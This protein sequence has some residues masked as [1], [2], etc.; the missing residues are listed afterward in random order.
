M[1]FKPIS[2]RNT[3]IFRPWD[4]CHNSEKVLDNIKSLE[5]NHP[6]CVPSSSSLIQCPFQTVSIADSKNMTSNH[7]QLSSIDSKL[8]CTKLPPNDYK[9]SSSTDFESSSSS[10]AS[11]MSI[12]NSNAS[13]YTSPE[14]QNMNHSL[15]Y[16]YSNYLKP[17]SSAQDSSS[18]MFYKPNNNLINLP[19]IIPV[20]QN[21]FDVTSSVLNQ[22]SKINAK[23]QRPK[24]FQCPHC[25]VCFSN[26]GQLKGHI[27]IHTGERP[28]ACDHANCGKTFTRNEELTRHKRIHTGLRPFSCSVCSKRFGRKDH[29]KKHIKTHQR[30]T[31]ISLPLPLSTG[32]LSYP[33]IGNY[34]PWFLSV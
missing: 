10:S 22:F 14:P 32:H 4:L 11:S 30:V 9:Y 28:F 24:R 31:S 19:N 15:Q 2:K 7:L 18:L 3:C 21:I 17:I 27:R 20:N 34:N 29:L 33:L 5:L 13:L 12:V 23:K 25:Q 1:A 16:Q 6:M 26:N 8:D